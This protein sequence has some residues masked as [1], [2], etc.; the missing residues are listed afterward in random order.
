MITA[1]VHGGGGVRQDPWE[2]D[3]AIKKGMGGVRDGAGG[4]DGCGL[5]TGYL[6]GWDELPC[7]RRRRGRSQEWE[8]DTSVKCVC[9]GV[10]S[11]TISLRA[12]QG[13]REALVGRR[14]EVY[15]DSGLLL[16][17][18]VVFQSQ[19]PL[20]R[21]LDQRHSWMAGAT[22]HQCVPICVYHCLG[23]LH[24][25]VCVSGGV[26]LWLRVCLEALRGCMA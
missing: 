6:Q 13:G 25:H 24:G 23:V 1:I 26:W 12:G 5:L 8:E 18:C 10:L 7:L 14:Y 15:L 4:T 11:G 19:L 9:G 17:L 22:P 3:F 21:S 20:K 2:I 16:C